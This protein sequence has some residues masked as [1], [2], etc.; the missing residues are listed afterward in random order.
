MIV[1]INWRRYNFRS[2]G[3]KMSLRG[4]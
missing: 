4:A 2:C 3:H 1:A